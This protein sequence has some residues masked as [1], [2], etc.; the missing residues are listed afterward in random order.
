MSV[1]LRASIA[2]TG[3]SKEKDGPSHARAAYKLIPFP[4]RVPMRLVPPGRSNPP[5]GGEIPYSGLSVRYHVIDTF[6]VHAEF[7]SRVAYM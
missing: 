1:K 2:A 6:T 4:H 3:R 5:D 7:N